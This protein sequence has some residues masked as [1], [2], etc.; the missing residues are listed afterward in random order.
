MHYRSQLKYRQNNDVF[1]LTLEAVG[2][3]WSRGECFPAECSMPV[4]LR[5]CSV[6]VGVG[7]L[8]R[9][10]VT[11]C[12]LATPVLSNRLTSVI[13]AYCLTGCMSK[14]F[15]T[16]TITIGNESRSR[17][18][19]RSRWARS[20]ERQQSD[21]RQSHKRGWEV[22]E[23]KFCTAHAPLTCSS[24][25]T[26]NNTLPLVRFEPRIAA[27]PLIFRLRLSRGRSQKVYVFDCGRYGSFVV[28]AVYLRFPVVLCSCTVE[29]H[30]LNCISGKVV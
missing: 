18:C 12:V 26:Y 20:P 19:E 8:T 21:E 5:V 4:N 30:G 7:V 29:N 17:A 27:V 2:W 24:T 28:F 3:E 11:F 14:R 23:R 9:I 1:E 22:V 15:L 16:V 13:A 25:Y 6:A 10:T